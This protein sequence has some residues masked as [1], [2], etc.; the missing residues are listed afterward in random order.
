MKGI[1]TNVLARYLVGDE[2]R[3]TARAVRFIERE[4]SKETPG[5][6]NRIVLSEL[7]WVLSGAYGYSRGQITKVLKLLVR[8]AELRV[9]DQDAAWSAIKDY[10]RGLC[11]FP[12]SYLALTNRYAGCELTVTF[13]SKAA[14]HQCFERL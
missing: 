12:D 8:T 4:C 6:V 13:D 9:E 10:E 3:Q 11:D 1:D 7:V 5:Y 14:R 2:P